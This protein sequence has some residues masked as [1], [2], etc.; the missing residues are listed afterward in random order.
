MNMVTRIALAVMAVSILG[1]CAKT[2]PPALLS[3]ADSLSIIQDNVVHRSNA[4]KFFGSDPNSPFIKDTTISFSGLRWFPVNPSFR[5][6]SQLHRYA[7][8]D[9]VVVLGTKGEERK[10]LR[11]GYFSFRVPHENGLPVVLKINAYKFTPYDTKRYALYKDNL[12]VWFTD[13]TTGKE[14]YGVGRYVEIGDEHS[15]PDHFYTIDLNKAYNPYCAYS[16]LFSCAIPRKEDHLDIAL[17][18]GEMTYHDEG[19][20]H[21]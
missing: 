7:R 1:G 12:S 18:V 3:S 14:S 20:S 19:Q 10:Q 4:D 11:Y 2:P 6:V 15:D 16:N 9:T 8:P 21:E 13:G 5:G 17:R